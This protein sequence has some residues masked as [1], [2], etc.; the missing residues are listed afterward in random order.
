MQLPLLTRSVGSA[1]RSMRA[2]LEQTLRSADLSFTEWTALAFTGGAPLRSSEVIQRQIA[3]H[4]IVD[5]AGGQESIDSLTRAGLIDR[6]QDDVLTHSEKGKAVFA[7]LSGEVE[8]ITRN[9]YGDLPIEDLEATHRTLTEI[10]KRA[11]YLLA[12]P[13]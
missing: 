2:L 6:S 3:G 12:R 11:G 7:R 10:A 8:G 13:S 4:V 9:L 5:A 1:E